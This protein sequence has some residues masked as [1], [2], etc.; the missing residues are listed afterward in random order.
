MQNILPKTGSIKD[1]VV[2]EDLL[3]ERK[4]LNF[5]QLELTNF[6]FGGE[7]N[8]KNYQEWTK[9]LESDPI[10]HNHHEFYEFTREEQIEHNLQ[11]VKRM[12]EI[13]KKKYFQDYSEGYFQWYY[14]IFKGISPYGLHSTMFVSC[15]DCLSDDEQR[16]KWLH[17]AK[18]FKMLGCY[19]QTELG[20]GSNVTGVETTATFD[21]QTDEI[22]INTPTITA[23]K[24]WPGELGKLTNFAMVYANLISN[25][26]NYGVQPFLV[27]IR[28]FENHQPVQ[29]VEIGDIG[30]KFGFNG[31]DNGF[32][33]F[34]NLR[35][36]RGNML[37]R[38]SELDREGNFKVK[39][40]QKALFSVMLM[41]R[42]QL[43]NFSS[44]GLHWALLVGT[45]YAAVRRQFANQEGDKLERK[46]LDYQTHMMKYGP[47]LA[48]SIA[49]RFAVTDLIKMHKKLLAGLVNNDFGNLELL[50]HITSGY[51]SVFTTLSYDAIDEI[52]Q[53]C[54]GAGFLSWSSLPSLQQDFAPNTTF[55]GDNTVMLQQAARLIMKNVT[56]VMKGKKPH[57]FFAHLELIKDL[58]VANK[59]LSSVSEVLELEYLDLALATR[60][61]F[62]IRF[63]ME[64][65]MTTEATENEKLNSLLAIDI[66]PMVKAHV[67]YTTFRHFRQ[68]IESNGFK[69]ENLKKHFR[70]LCRLYALNELT[71]DNQ[72]LYECGFF[73]Q[74]TMKIISQGLKQLLQEIRPHMIPLV[75]SLRIPDSILVSSIG[76]SYGDI[77]ETQLEWAKGSRL[78]KS[79]TIK[80]FKELILPIVNGKL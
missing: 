20:H 33:I 52:R 63:F 54:G 32:I 34:N 29:G 43:I 8:Y 40:N 69:C 39:G 56:L 30:S 48:Y 37:Q 42:V 79:T 17:M 14:Y 46:L 59:T 15:I 45:R 55:E 12:Y 24:F 4:N 9:I 49:F 78:N 66:L 11:K 27:Q 75:E 23:T 13:D 5:D 36:P 60:A 1:K 51:K 77:Y 67:M 76:N 50:H 28:D 16:A 2:A 58:P 26:K 72:S 64:K 38:F 21:K 57:E 41:G 47:F 22:I 44:F 10:L 65:Y 35:I 3:A 19:A 80:G 74:G 25:G 18:D 73:T 53:S 68:G 6:V 71:Q 70:N 7:E 62:K 61:A 31:K